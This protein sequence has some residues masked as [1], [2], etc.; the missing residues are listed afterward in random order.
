MQGGSF[1]I[2]GLYPGETV[3]VDTCLLFIG[4]EFNGL[5]SYGLDDNVL[6][7]PCVH[8]IWVFE[9]ADCGVRGGFLGVYWVK[10]INPSSFREN[11]LSTQTKRF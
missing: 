7:C 10:H 11:Y 9:G 6:E 8:R 1:P 4:D 2:Q 5:F 3:K